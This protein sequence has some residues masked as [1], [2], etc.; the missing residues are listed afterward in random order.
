MNSG[1]AR[2]RFAAARVARLATAGTGCRP[3]LVPVVFAVRD[4]TV[5]SAVDAKP[6]R[7][8]SLRRLANVAAN[9]AVSLLVDHYEDDWER[10]WWVR[11]DGRGR[12]LDGSVPEAAR[13]IELLHERYPQQRAT[14]AVLAV[15]VERWSGWA[16][17]GG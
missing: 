5:Y 17:D 16:A 10:L 4:D 1:E 3:H 8:T 11:A 9:P 2:Q 13:A 14:G 12:V 6:K 7:T 15:D